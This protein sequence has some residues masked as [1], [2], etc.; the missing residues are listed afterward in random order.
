MLLKCFPK[1]TRT[2]KKKHLAICKKWLDYEIEA[3]KPFLILSFGNTG[4]LFFRGEGSGIISIN[5]RTFW[6][7]N[8]NCWITHCVH[9]AMATYSPENMPLLEEGIDEFVKK[10]NILM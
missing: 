3:I 9:P 1:T 8:Y 7:D 4:N 10:L 6:N 5:G 2:P